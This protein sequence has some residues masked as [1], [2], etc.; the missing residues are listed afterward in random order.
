[1]LESLQKRALRIIY[2]DMDYHISLFLAEL[3]T[4]YSRR[5]HLTQRFYKWNIDCSLS[6]LDYLLPEQRDFVTKLRRA[7]KYE[8]F[9]TRTDNRTISKLLYRVLCILSLIHI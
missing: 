7:N 9:R 4:V 8:S 6:C 2:S 1:M 5:E 3:D